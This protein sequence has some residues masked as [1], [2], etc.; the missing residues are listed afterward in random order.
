MRL[1]RRSRIRLKGA[2]TAAESG[3]QLAT[4]RWRLARGDDLF[5][6]VASSPSEP[7]AEVGE[8][9]GCVFVRLM[10]FT[11]GGNMALRLDDKKAMVA[12]VAAVAATAQSVVA[13]EYRGLTVT[14]MT[15]LRVEGAQVRRL[16]ASREEHAGPQGDRRHSVRVRRQESQGSADSRVLEG[17][18]GRSGAPGQ[19]LR[20]RQR[21]AGA[22]RR[23][24]RR[25]RR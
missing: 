19:G 20:Q 8:R 1:H 24:A 13:A 23:V 12:E 5:W 14:Q 6:P 16:S 10:L 2:V 15:D 4:G 22:D 18:S 9:A 17:R 25:A 3:G 21:Q 7:V 11:P